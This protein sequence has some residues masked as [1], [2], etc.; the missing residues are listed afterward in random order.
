M[1]HCAR[2]Q[3][4]KCRDCKQTCKSPIQLGFSGN[5][6]RIDGALHEMNLRYFVARVGGGV[7]VFDGQDES[8]S[9]AE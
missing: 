7:Y 8:S 9:P 4:S 6:T 2:R 3:I 5:I 1:R